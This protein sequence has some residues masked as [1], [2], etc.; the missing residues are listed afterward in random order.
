MGG[1]N[2][3]KVADQVVD[4]PR[5]YELCGWCS[6]YRHMHGTLPLPG[7]RKR[8][9]I[10]RMAPEGAGCPTCGGNLKVVARTQYFSIPTGGR[11]A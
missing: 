1:G 11:N 9:A 4:C 2:L 6:D 8:C 5:C 3:P 10:E 7:S